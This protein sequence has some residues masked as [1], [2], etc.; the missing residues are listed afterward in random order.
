MTDEKH[1]TLKK[2]LFL[3]SIP[4]FSGL[5]LLIAAQLFKDRP[6]NAGNTLLPPAKPDT[7]PPW[8]SWF[9]DTAWPLLWGAVTGLWDWITTT[10]PIQNWLLCLLILSAIGCVVFAAMYIRLRYFSDMPA[11]QLEESTDTPTTRPEDTVTPASGMTAAISKALW[12]PPE[13]KH[14][15]ARPYIRP[16]LLIDNDE[17]PDASQD[18]PT[19]TDLEYVVLSYFAAEEIDEAAANNIAE[20]LEDEPETIKARLEGLK[21]KR[22]VEYRDAQFASSIFRIT[23]LGKA[24]LDKNGISKSYP[25]VIKPLGAGV[26]SG[27]VLSEECREVLEC[28]AEREETSLLDIQIANRLEIGKIALSVALDDLQSKGYLTMGAYDG[29]NNATEYGLTPKA[30]AYMKAVGMI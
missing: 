19:I 22:Y 11:S 15:E 4:L 13:D 14:S 5:T 8:Y 26:D 25:Q 17:L 6:E 21:S 29:M 23:K 20:I 9:T 3:V 16:T 18:A 7:S 28:Y 24:Y 1:H 2:W 27:D 10:H 30:K 12:P